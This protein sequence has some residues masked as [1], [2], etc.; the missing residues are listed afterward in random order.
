MFFQFTYI[1]PRSGVKVI[2][3]ATSTNAGVWG[4]ADTSTAPSLLPLTEQENREK[5]TALVLPKPLIVVCAIPLSF[6]FSLEMSLYFFTP[7]VFV[8]SILV[9]MKLSSVGLVQVRYTSP[10]PD[11]VVTFV[12]LAG[13]LSLSFIRPSPSSLHELKMTRHQPK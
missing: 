4:D 9:Y 7:F 13:A 12:T 5:E 1:P 2:V 8:Y 3:L 11:S 6:A 10:G